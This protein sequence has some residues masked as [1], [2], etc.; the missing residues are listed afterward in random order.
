MRQNHAGLFLTSCSEVKTIA[1]VSAIRSVSPM[2]SYWC[3]VGEGI[4]DGLSG[5][6]LEEM[7]D[8]CPVASHLK[9]LSVTL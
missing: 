8:N 5:L 9:P 7:E 4:A 2:F 1:H 6:S 3:P